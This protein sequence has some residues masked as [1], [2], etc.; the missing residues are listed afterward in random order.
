[1]RRRDSAGAG[2]QTE[3]AQLRRELH[4]AQEQQTATAGVLKVIS[5]STFD[6]QTV[7]DTLVQSA[8]RLCQDESAFLF[9][10]EG[11]DYWPVYQLVASC[12]FSEDY[13]E[14][15]KAN[16]IIP[17]R[18][19]LVGRT[20]LEG[21][22]IHIA[23][24]LADAEYHW[25]ESQRRGKY[26]TMLGVPLLRE[27]DPIG[28]LALTRSQVRPFSDK[29]I[30]LVMTFADQALIA[31]ENTR[32]L[33][34]LRQR[35][36]SLRDSEARYALVTEAASEGIYEWNIA[37][38]DLH[39]SPRLN[40]LFGFETGELT[41]QNWIERV[42]PDERETYRRALVSH[43][44]GSERHLHCE[45]RVLVKS[46]EYHWV[47]DH[48]V[49]VRNQAG[50]AVRLVGSVSDIS[51]RKA[52]EMA[53]SERTRE[54]SESLEQQTATSQILRVISSSP[55]ELQPVFQAILENATR[56]CQASFGVLL[57]REGDSFRRVARH[58]APAKFVEFSNKNP[59]LHRHESISLNRIMETK[60]A[61]HVADMMLEEP[62]M[63]ITKLGGARTLLTVPM[64]KEDEL[65]GAIG[66][67]RQEVRPFTEKQI[68]LVQNF[69]A[70]AVIAIE[71]ARLLNELRQS[72]TDLT[73]SLERQTA[74]A[75]VL[76]VISS[77]PGDL[78]PVFEAMLSN[79]MRICAA[80]FGHLLLY[81][82]EAFTAAALHNSPPLY[83]EHWKRG[84]VRL[85]PKTGVGRMVATKQV[86]HIPDISAETAYAERDPIRVITVE[87]AGARTFLA[88]PMLKDQNLIGAIVIYRQEVRPFS[89][90]Q[91][92][93]L[94]N[95]AAQAVIAIENARLLNELRQRTDDLSESL[96]QQIAT[97]DVLKII[98]RSTFDL[99]NVLNT[100]VESAA[101]LCEADMAAIHR[102]QGTNYQAVAIHGLPSDDQEFLRRRIP[103]EAGRGTVVGR[104][105]LECKP[106]QVSDVLADPD[107][108]LRDVQEKEGFRTL[109][110][111]PLLREGNPIG[112]IVLMRR[113]VRPFTDKQIELVT[114]FADQAVIAIENVRL[115]EE[116]QARTSELARSV[117]E[118]RALGEVGQAVNSTLDVE[119]V[120]RT[121]VTKAVELSAT[122]AGAIYVFDEERREFRLRATYGMT[123]A[124]I[125]AI[126]DRHIGIGDANIGESARRRE[127][128][129]IADLREAP[130]SGVNDILLGAGYRA[131]LVVPL[132]GPDRIVGALVVR[133]KQP[134]AFPQA[135]VDLLQTFGNQ[136]V[137]AIQNARLFREIEEKGRE[138][139][140]ASKHKSQFLA[141]MS[142][143]LRTPLNAII[144]VT[145]MLREDASDL[146]REDEIEP[147]DRV[148]R[149]ARHLLGLINDILDLSKVE[150]GKMEIHI[151]EFAIAPVVNDAVKTI[152]TLAAKNNNRLVVNCKPEIGVMQADQ[153]R[154]RQALL[155]LLSNANKF[156]EGGTV[157]IDAQR[158]REAGRDWITMAVADTGI[159]MTPEQVGKLFQEFSQADSSTTRKY[160]GTGLGLAISRRFCQLM[161]GD[162]TVKSELGRGSSFT[163]RLPAAGAG[164]VLPALQQTSAAPS[165]RTGTGNAP[166]I[167]IIDDDITVRDL[168][169]RFLER[170]GFS[171]AKAD[172]GKEGLRMARE[173]HPAAVTLDIMMPD[174][175]GWTVL[176]AIK[177]DPDLVDLPV[178]LMTI[179][180]EK[181]RGYALGATEYLVK[182]V[183]RQKLMDVLRGLCGSAGR[184]LLMVD[185]DDL[186]RRQMRAALEQQ[187]WTVTEA[188]DGRDALTRLSEARPDVIILDL[189]MPEMDGFAFLE[190][191]RR[192][193]EW[194]DIPVVVVTAKDL[195]DADRRR[196]NG[197][198]ER[199]IQKT[200]R[201]DML[202]EVRSVLAKRVERPRS[203][204][205]AGT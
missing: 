205:P 154:V 203:V 98:S 143:E 171:V 167:L 142:H 44:K 204:P 51:A 149:A 33:S 52:A 48:G 111:V 82:G 22:T 95:F 178:V 14:Y 30:E 92:E 104:A 187:G 101:R 199:I 40:E 4:D 127:P 38:N 138:L 166:L 182:P 11:D 123:E 163:I 192:K 176:A 12:G 9:R 157:T 191:M 147:L 177:G 122:D 112:V 1:V 96:Q 61:D 124:M 63:P 66:I 90:K 134:G 6:L 21:H 35:E 144:G 77:S 76:S 39:L 69:A 196:L 105:V 202:R 106:V 201:D 137:L 73:E 58:N 170:E 118:L 189:M 79:A 115:F 164:A 10:R 110:G 37:G 109:L 54:L 42:H 140:E 89:D 85:G 2:L 172:G 194:R 24:C 43:F 18:D 148:L 65:I 87:L 29:Q 97:A 168:V 80:N 46:G 67:Y 180:D 153:T 55:G 36:A 126:S 71:N 3:L 119:T 16:P 56:I 174:L 108:T 152:E 41:S 60:Q 158:H 84:P 45:Y 13:V 34:E 25:P 102:Q 23:D 125:A 155:N 83:A 93:L 193:A 107:Y 139:A 50:R 91:I 195:T 100:L 179:V 94:S 190:E 133:R 57:L 185:D 62:E 64:L 19:T 150:A 88:V 116:V 53:V 156:T 165:V 75:Q 78:K 141:N 103:F 200:D 121:I 186:G 120:L 117:G 68:A 130:A 72:T 74:T 131:L 47:L 59:L 161:D 49:A 7:L 81:D 128:I 198:V 136:S 114:T 162:I 132:L 160:G 184:P 86:V 146:K 20:A 188:T 99:Q 181:N 113:T 135:A 169:G 17:G 197:G 5:R 70:Q 31:I 159:G 183:D 32:L 145:E 15:M 28:V 27:G 175:D 129:Q 151:E 173:L 26:R 8:A